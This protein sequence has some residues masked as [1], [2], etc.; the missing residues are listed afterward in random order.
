MSSGVR[1]TAP[2]VVQAVITTERA[3]SARAI[4]VTTFDAVPPGQQAT[5]I[6][7]TASGGARSVSVAT[8]QP[9]SGMM[10]NWPKNPA[11]TV[12]GRE[13][14]RAKSATV[15]VIPIP[16]MISA[17]P[18]MIAASENQAKAAG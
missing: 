10:R 14:T 4:A 6:R 3:T 7:P 12:A 16:N 8:V 2:S 17:K 18:A 15:R 1:T 9:A 5:R 11:A 13:A